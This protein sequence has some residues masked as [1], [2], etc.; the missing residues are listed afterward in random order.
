M[1]QIG[2]SEIP[3]RRVSV[4]WNDKPKVLVSKFNIT[5]DFRK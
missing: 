4:E 1:I 5:G 2:G 3:L